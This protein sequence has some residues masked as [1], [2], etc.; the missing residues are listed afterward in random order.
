MRRGD[1][2]NDGDGGN[3]CGGAGDSPTHHIIDVECESH[4]GH[5][6][7]T[8]AHLVP[9]VSTRTGKK[10]FLLLLQNYLT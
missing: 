3:F 6:D 4:D 9:S 10:Y 2:I 1:G 7:G 5:G 8:S